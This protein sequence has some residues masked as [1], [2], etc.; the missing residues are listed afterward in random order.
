MAPRPAL[1][2]FMEGEALRRSPAKTE[3]QKEAFANFWKRAAWTDEERRCVYSLG[4]Y[5]LPA[6]NFK[7]EILKL[8]L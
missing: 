7:T 8:C 2:T 6:L 5:G 4:S 1:E 3:N